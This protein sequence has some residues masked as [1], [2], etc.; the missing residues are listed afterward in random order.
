[1]PRAAAV[2]APQV[3]EAEWQ[4]QVVDLAKICGWRVLHVYALRRAGS[5]RTPTT[6]V[7]WP[8]LVLVRGERMIVAELKTQKGKLSAEQQGWLD[9]LALVEGVQV[10]VWRPADQEEVITELT[11]RPAVVAR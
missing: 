2:K 9:A 10:F 4:Q 6:T 5:Y 3:S 11:G 8:D 1:M 7:G